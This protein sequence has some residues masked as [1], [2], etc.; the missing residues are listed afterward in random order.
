MWE[1]KMV[2]IY[3]YA[4][5]GADST[6]THIH[7]NTHTVT[8]QS[9]LFDVRIVP[10]HR[11][12]CLF[13]C[14]CACFVFSTH[15]TER[16]VSLSLHCRLFVHA[17]ILLRICALDLYD[18][19]LFELNLLISSLPYS[20]TLFA[21]TEIL[22]NISKILLIGWLAQCSKTMKLTHLFET[23]HCFDFNYDVRLIWTFFSLPQWI[24]AFD[25]IKYIKLDSHLY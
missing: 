12:V 11:S 22:Q 19:L 5:Y 15:H 2:L 20:H 18:M 25:A 6:H 17:H 24:L 7:K 13:L 1:I 8:C 3:M 14:M 10:A 4:S 21:C 16:R 23:K 9:I